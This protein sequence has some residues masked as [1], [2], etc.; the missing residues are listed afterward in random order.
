MGETIRVITE[1]GEQR[2]LYSGYELQRVAAA[3]ND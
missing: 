1:Q 2:Q 3:W